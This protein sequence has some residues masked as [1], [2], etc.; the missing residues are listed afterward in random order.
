MSAPSHFPH[1]AGF[2]DGEEFGGAPHIEALRSAGL[3]I[4]GVGTALPPNI[5]SQSSN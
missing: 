4:L 2:G 3:V 5:I 1:I